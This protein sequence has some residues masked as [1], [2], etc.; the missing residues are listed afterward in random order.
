M[1]QTISQIVPSIPA[2]PLAENKSFRA[3][4]SVAILVLTVMAFKIPL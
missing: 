2:M 4:L 1:A 3:A